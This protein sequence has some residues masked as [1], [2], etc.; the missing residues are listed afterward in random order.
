MNV[1]S[2]AH[3]RPDLISIQATSFRRYGHDFSVVTNDETGM[4]AEA[5]DEASV[6]FIYAEIPFKG[7]D[8]RASFEAIGRAWNL[9]GN[10][11][12]LLVESDVFLVG[13]IDPI[14]GDKKMACTLYWRNRPEEYV[15]HY[16][17]AV[18]VDFSVVKKHEIDWWW[19]DIVYD[20]LPKQCKKAGIELVSWKIDRA[21]GEAGEAG[22]R[23]CGPNLIHMD[24]AG[25]PLPPDVLEEKNRVIRKIIG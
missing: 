4:I 20:G 21:L 3:N 5:C 24:K 1:V 10:V 6:D 7:I 11:P 17:N 15:S 12:S 13:D 2:I 18:M 19:K 16:P 8:H 14:V 9:S 25:K 23:W 22:F